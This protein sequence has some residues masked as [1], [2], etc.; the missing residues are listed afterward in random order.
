MADIKWTAQEVPL[1]GRGKRKPSVQKG[2]RRITKP[3]NGARRWRVCASTRSARLI[4]ARSSSPTPLRL[5]A[6]IGRDEGVKILT[7]LC[8]PTPDEAEHWAVRPV[9]RELARRG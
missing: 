3:A 7:G 9:R 2:S 8:L 4:E 1:I 6:R 5:E